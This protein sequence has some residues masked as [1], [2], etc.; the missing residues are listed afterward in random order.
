[1]K[2]SVKIFAGFLAVLSIIASGYGINYYL[3]ENPK[4]SI[5]KGVTYSS[6]IFRD[7]DDDYVS[8]RIP[9][10]IYNP[11][12]NTLFAFAEG[13]K[14]SGSDFGNIDLVM[15]R[16]FN[17]GQTWEPMQII[18]DYNAIAVQNPCPIYIPET[19]MILLHV[20]VN[21]TYHYMINSTDNGAT[22]GIPQKIEA[23][24]PNTIYS[25]P[26]PGHATRL[27]SGRIL[28][29]GM[30]IHEG[31][32][33]KEDPNRVWGSHIIYSDDLGQTWQL[34]TV[35]PPQFNEC[36]LTQTSNGSVL[37][38]L[39]AT[40]KT[41]NNLYSFLSYSNDEGLTSNEPVAQSELISPICQVSILNFQGSTSSPTDDILLYSGPD[42]QTERV[43][44]TIKMSYDNGKTWNQSRLLFEGKSG[45]SDLVQLNT[46]HIGCM[47]ENGRYGY[48]DYITFAACNID[49]L[50]S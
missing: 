36:I 26:A 33:M 42:S 50:Q 23:R 48:N 19:N 20:Y 22:W 32:A 28:I 2:K 34:G 10:I 31:S 8:Y 35:Y 39:R 46:T 6:V 24:P 47:F 21:R 15:K 14:E 13:R 16:S 9:A 1:M 11:D 43:K 45:Y 30:H 37:M 18:W 29:P 38:A 17:G 7:G 27:S 3:I 44:M 40:N 12:N 49:F 41:E 4:Y 25:G 5:E